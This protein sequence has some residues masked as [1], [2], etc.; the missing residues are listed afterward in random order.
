MDLDFVGLSTLLI[1]A[2][3][4]GSG[5]VGWYLTWRQLK[6]RKR[7]EA[8]RVFRE[9]ILTPRILRIHQDAIHGT[10]RD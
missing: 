6:D 9:F 3:L 2:G 4:G 10:D 7:I 5:L 1:G 8:Q